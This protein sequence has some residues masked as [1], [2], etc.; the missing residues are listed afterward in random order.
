MEII[1]ASFAAVFSLFGMAMVAIGVLVGMF[2]GAMPGL[3]PSIGIALLIPFTYTIEPQYA[4][5]L[6]V[7]LYMAAEYGGSISAILLSTPG[8]A[9]AAA[10]VID[11]YPMGRQGRTGEALGISLTASS[12]G[13][14]VGAVALIVFA[15]PLAEV[16][17]LISPAGYFAIGLFGLTTVASLSGG[18]MWKGLVGAGF[19]L[20]VSTIG[21]DPIAGMPRF[22][23]GF[24]ELYE[25]IPVLAALIGLFALSE[26]FAMAE[27]PGALERV[28]EKFGLVFIGFK[29]LRHLFGTMMMGNY[30]Q[31]KQM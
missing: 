18:S 9:A 25:G 12:V 4:L 10:T 17:L 21:I 11:G 28:K 26:A 6:L 22:A 8:T 1:A 30:Y 19:G 24:Y 16:A 3:G 7:S 13:G 20:A 5:L 27:N 29:Q 2:V 14:L 31:L 15:K 23:F